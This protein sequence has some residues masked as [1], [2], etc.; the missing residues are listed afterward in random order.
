M[1]QLR[2]DAKRLAL[3]NVLLTTVFSILSILS[4][5]I[6]CGN[7]LNMH[8]KAHTVLM[9]VVGVP[10]FA[11]LFYLWLLFLEDLKKAY[12][13]NETIKNAVC[14]GQIAIWLKVAASVIGFI[15]ASIVVNHIGVRNVSITSYEFGIINKGGSIELICKSLIA[16]SAPFTAIMYVLLWT[17]SERKSEMRVITM[18]LAVLALF[19]MTATVKTFE[20]SS[21][22]WGML[23]LATPVVEYLFLW[24]I[25][26]GAEFK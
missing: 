2:N 12:E 16:A 17:V 9:S 8:L 10:I 3:L 6:F 23:E 25:Y 20:E 21:W 19:Y 14:V 26:K 5:V 24:K 18:V 11:I 15:A 22:P 7:T 1:E 4:L 13:G